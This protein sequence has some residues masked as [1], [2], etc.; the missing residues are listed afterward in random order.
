GQVAGGAPIFAPP[1][2]VGQAQ[3]TV[4]VDPRL[5]R[6]G[7]G[8]IYALRVRGASMRDAGIFDGDLVFVRHTQTALAQQ[9]VVALLGD[10]ATVKT[11]VPQAQGVV[12][13]AA[14]PAFADI[15]LSPAQSAALQI[16]GVV[17]GVF[18][19]L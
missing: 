7:R 13:R 4:E 6:R 3:E 17:V 10:E 9:I 19:Q 12:L 18:R 2:E 15:V 14:N 1:T 5:L 16:M 8:T 11:F